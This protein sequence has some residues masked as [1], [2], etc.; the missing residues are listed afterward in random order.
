MT[1]STR[2]ISNIIHSYHHLPL[3]HHPIRS[4]PSIVSRSSSTLDHRPKKTSVEPIV[5]Y[6]R[7]IQIQRN[8]FS[9]TTRVSIKTKKQKREIERQRLKRNDLRSQTS[10]HLRLKYKPDPILGYSTSIPNG[11]LSWQESELNRLILKPHDVWAGGPQTTESIEATHRRSDPR[12]DPRTS[13]SPPP[14]PSQP[15]LNFGLDDHDGYRRSIILEGLP[16]IEALLD[17]DPTQP[18]PSKPTD[19]A[20]ELLVD[21]KN[22]RLLR[23]LDLRNSNSSGIDRVNKARIL[24]AFSP[25]DPRSPHKLDPGCSQVQAAI[26]TYRIHTILRHAWDNSRDKDAKRH[27]SNLVMKRMK[28]LKYLRRSKP[29]EYFKL[30]PRIGLQPSYLRDE[31]IVRSKLPLRPGESPD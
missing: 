20:Q 13:T 15:I 25:I 24:R 6:R 3:T 22:Q 9:S 10:T 1:I 21:Q 23:I 31:L 19:D 17:L 26:I 27:L 14:P 18:K 12:A 5:D 7:S 8:F 11:H 29:K 28:I 16:R 4:I 2:S 30:L